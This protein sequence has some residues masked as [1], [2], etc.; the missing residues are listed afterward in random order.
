MKK[1]LLLIFCFGFIN[2]YCQKAVN[3]YHNL[4][5]KN[6]QRVPAEKIIPIQHTTDEELRAISLRWNAEKVIE[7]PTVHIK[8]LNTD[9]KWT[10]NEAFSNDMHFE[11]DGKV[12][13]MLPVYIPIDADSISLIVDNRDESSLEVF[14]NIFTAVKA[15]AETLKAQSVSQLGGCFCSTL[16]FTNRKAWGCPQGP[17]TYN[18]SKVSHLIVHHAAGSNSS[19]N[20]SAVVLSIWNFHTGTNGWADVGYN[21]LV[22]PNGVLYEGRGGGENAIGAHFC[23]KNTNTMGVCMLGN[24]STV[25]PTE[26]ALNTLSHIL[27]WKACDAEINPTNA[28]LHP[29]SAAS[30]NTISGHRDGCATDCPG[31]LMY[32]K[33]PSLRTKVQSVIS[34]CLLS[35]QKDLDY[36][37]LKVFPNPVAGDLLH[38][39]GIDVKWVKIY[40]ANGQLLVSLDNISDNQ[41]NVSSLCNG[42]FIIQAGDSQSNI[43]TTSFLK[44]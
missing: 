11:S 37:H 2:S 19:T 4:H 7:P 28:I 13:T 31:N 8:W 33:L 15:D 16:T 9:K 23:G 44:H 10:K 3:H 35:N 36:Y 32:P 20:W 12:G 40:A 27:H 17:T 21:W 29:G 30:L 26:A 38:L 22:D 14:V 18:Y 1:A 39:E 42:S 6:N 5:F 34:A 24:L 43:R 41:V 25:E